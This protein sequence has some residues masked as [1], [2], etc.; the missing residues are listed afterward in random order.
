MSIM[1]TATRS[2]AELLKSVVLSVLD[3]CEDGATICAL[4]NGAYN[5]VDDL[6]SMNHEDIV[7]L[8]YP[9]EEA[10]G[11]KVYRPLQCGYKMKLHLLKEW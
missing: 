1:A 10:E 11:R 3:D 8:E 4:N 5:T 2:K 9:E 6:L 7:Q